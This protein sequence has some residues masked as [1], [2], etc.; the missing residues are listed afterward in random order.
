LAGQEIDMPKTVGAY[1]A[2]TT[3]PACSMRPTPVV[4]TKHSVP[5]A[6]LVPPTGNRPDA[7][8]MVAAWRAFRE[9]EDIRLGGMSIREMIEDGRR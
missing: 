3:S 5:V 8:K 1:E 9:R 7:A 2:K 4:I 6:Q